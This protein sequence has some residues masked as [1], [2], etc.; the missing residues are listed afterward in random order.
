MNKKITSFRFK[1]GDILAKKYIVQNRLG[2]GWEGE[3]FLVKEKNTGVERAAKLFYPHRNK[4]NKVLKFYART[5]HKLKDCGIVIQYYSQEEFQYQNQTVHFLLS[6]FVQGKLLSQ[7][8]KEQPGKRLHSFQALHLLYALACGL[9][10]IH[11]NKQYHGDIHLDN[12][13]IEKYGLDF[14]IKL[15]DLFNWDNHSTRAENLKD[16]IVQSIKVFY[17]VLGGKKWYPKQDPT[18]KEICCGLQK[19]KILKK[20]RNM[21]KL[22]EHLEKIEF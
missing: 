4:N 5:L 1:E 22:R 20:F 2:K 8:L 12:I 16:D 18:I 19:P 9:E 6:E 3:V 13:I 7:F 21:M 14:K 15:I 17:E 11:K 10:K